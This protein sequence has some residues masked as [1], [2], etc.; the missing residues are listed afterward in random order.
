M[1]QSWILSIL[2]VGGGWI[3][4]W[5]RVM[6]SNA[7]SCRRGMQRR[8]GGFVHYQC[9]QFSR[10]LSFPAVAHVQ[11]L[12]LVQHCF[13]KFVHGTNPCSN[14]ARQNRYCMDNAFRSCEL[15]LPEGEVSFLVCSQ[16]FQF[17]TAHR[18]RALIYR[19]FLYS[20]AGKQR[21]GDLGRRF[22]SSLQ[23]FAPD[24]IQSS[25]S[26]NKCASLTNLKTQSA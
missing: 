1:L 26:T 19:G 3:N 24:Q 9:V 22:F 14:F 15:M 25:S 11:P 13:V 23:C 2:V 16:L 10:K 7:L 4:V 12:H 6:Q 8:Q 20:W 18:W 5:Q 17:L 21:F